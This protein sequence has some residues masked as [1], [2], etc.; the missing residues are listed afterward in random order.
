[1]TY[2]PA[3]KT[4][5]MQSTKPSANKIPLVVILLTTLIGLADA[6]YLTYQHYSGAGLICNISHGCERVLTS[7]FATVAG[8]PVALLG[9]IYYIFVM[10]MAVYFMTN[11]ANPRILLLTGLAGFLPTIYLLSLQAF[12][13]KAWCQY[14]LLSSLTA[15]II[16]VVTVLIFRS[17]YK[18]K[19][20]DDDESKA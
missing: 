13:I 15:T 12:V 17:S 6:S 7:Q 1:M 20:R 9:V 18:N 14:C 3:L 16:F 19:K 4:L 5:R 2:S 11:K 8:I 10:L